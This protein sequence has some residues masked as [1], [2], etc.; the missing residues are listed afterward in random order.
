MAFFQVITAPNPVLSYF[1]LQSFFLHCGSSSSLA[2]CQATSNIGLLGEHRIYS[3]FRYMAETLVLF[4][5]N[6]PLHNNSRISL[7]SHPFRIALCVICCCLSH[8]AITHGNME[9]PSDLSSLQV[10][11]SIFTYLHVAATWFH[12]ASCLPSC[13]LCWI[14]PTPMASSTIYYSSL[15]Y[16]EVLM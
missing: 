10:V 3:L 11:S 2:N 7:D 1:H 9:T 13:H 4:W 15:L 6:C 14:Q 16:R 8:C 5:C 12:T